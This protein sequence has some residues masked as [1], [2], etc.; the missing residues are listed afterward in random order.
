MEIVKEIVEYNQTGMFLAKLIPILLGLPL[1]IPIVRGIFDWIKQKN[2]EKRFKKISILLLIYIVVMAIIYTSLYL[3]ISENAKY[4]SAKVK[5][6]AILEKYQDEGNSKVTAKLKGKDNQIINI[7]MNSNDVLNQKERINRG[8]KVRVKSDKAYPL[9]KQ[10]SIFT[11]GK[12][13]DIEYKLKK[14]SELVKVE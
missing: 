1:L 11:S 14:G 4:T 2:E 7:K 6:H 5:G 9:T 13:E 3:I 12:S 8:D 10:E